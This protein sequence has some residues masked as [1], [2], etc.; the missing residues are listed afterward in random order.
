MSLYIQYHNY[1]REGLPLG[2]GHGIHTGLKHVLKA[3]GGQVFLIVG[4]GQ[5]R[6]YY[7]WDSFTVA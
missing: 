2:D 7:L 1:D 5:P 3:T 6:R 4:I